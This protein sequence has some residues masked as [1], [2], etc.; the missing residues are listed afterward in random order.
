MT[1]LNDNKG[2]Y[3]WQSLHKNGHILLEDE[4]EKIP[5]LSQIPSNP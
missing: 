4:N 1:D 3:L 5:P 2:I